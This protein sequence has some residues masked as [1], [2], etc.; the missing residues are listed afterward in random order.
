LNN[1]AL[2]SVTGR[3]VGSAKDPSG[4]IIPGAQVTVTN[5]ETHVSQVV[6]TNDLR[7][8]GCE[9]G[10]RTNGE[11][12][13]SDYSGFDSVLYR[14]HDAKWHFSQGN[15]TSNELQMATRESKPL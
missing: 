15:A 11:P 7:A 3:I 10:S 12:H 5:T 1:T 6:S 14:N 8:S 13:T 4:A 2:A 9:S